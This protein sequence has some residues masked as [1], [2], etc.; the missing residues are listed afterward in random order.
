VLIVTT[1]EIPGYTVRAVMGEVF[2]ITVRS[3]NVGA[4]LVAGFRAL[5]G[6]E[7]PEMT[8]LLVQSRNEAMARMIHEARTRGA[9]AIVGMRYDTGEI[10]NQW[11]EIC[12]YGTAVWVEP[13]T[14]DARRQYDAM[15]ASGQ[16]PHQQDYSTRVGEFGPP[17]HAPGRQQTGPQQTGP[18][19]GA[20]HP[21]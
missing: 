2:G 5:A 8:R 16:L 9:N 11:N 19:P 17:P 15:A 3:R 20:H 7:L 18:Q 13:V 12:A 1:N 6:G 14:E 4:N 10:A 21:G